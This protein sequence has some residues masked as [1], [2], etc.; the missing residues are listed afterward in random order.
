MKNK[1]RLIILFF[2]IITLNIGCKSKTKL[3]DT[4]QNSIC[5]VD[6]INYKNLS[7]FQDSTELYW[8]KIKGEANIELNNKNY[9]IDIQLRIKPNELIWISLSK[10]GFPVAKFLLQKDSVFGLDLF[11]KEYLKSDYSSL[12]SKIGVGLDFQSI[13]SILLGKYIPFKGEKNN[14]NNKQEIIVSNNSKDSLLFFQ[15]SKVITKQLI[16]AQWLNCNDLSV[17]KQFIKTANE[18]DIW[19]KFANLDSTSELVIPLNVELKA[20]KKGNKILSAKLE[21]DKVKSSKSLN[22]PFEIPVDY[23]EME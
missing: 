23:V 16:W 4:K 21:Y 6:S 7:S 9:L 19:T 11:H 17:N 15:D 20:Y 5:L 1:L 13:Q 14:W 12:N 18:E 22:I 10:A 3:V 8:Y 2:A